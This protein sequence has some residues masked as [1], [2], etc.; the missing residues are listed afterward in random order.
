MICKP[1]KRPWTLILFACGEC[2]QALSVDHKVDIILRK[3]VP[4]AEE[5]EPNQK[6]AKKAMLVE[7]A[8]KGSQQ[9]KACTRLRLGWSGLRERRERA[10]FQSASF[11]EVRDAKAKFS[12]SLSTS[13][14]SVSS[15]DSD[16]QMIPR[17]WLLPNATVSVSRHVWHLIAFLNYQQVVQES[18]SQ[19]TSHSPGFCSG[20]SLSIAF[21]SFLWAPLIILTW[22]LCTW[23]ITREQ[24]ASLKHILY[25]LKCVKYK[26][27]IKETCINYRTV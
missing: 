7:S 23:I 8:R 12:I 14:A 25:L 15:P 20:E 4:R 6:L 21:P 26:C 2:L 16:D 9:T 5:Q 10:L 1:Q 22:L 27:R 11:P 17:V 13:P 24:E 3:W 18:P 19:W